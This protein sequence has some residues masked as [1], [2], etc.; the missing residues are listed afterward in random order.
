MDD[1][2]LLGILLTLLLCQ[3]FVKIYACLTNDNWKQL[4]FLHN[5][6]YFENIQFP[7]PF[8][9][10][11]ENMGIPGRNMRPAGHVSNIIHDGYLSLF[12]IN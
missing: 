5:F 11:A 6:D 3:N 8:V 9:K 10:P 12:L 1:I 4:L 2:T 7:F